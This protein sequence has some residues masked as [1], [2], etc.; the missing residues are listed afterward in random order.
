MVG[1]LIKQQ[2]IG[3]LPDDQ[4]QHQTGFFAAGEALGDFGDF[5]ALEAKTAEIIT[6]LLFHFL[7]SKARHVLNR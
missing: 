6:Q 1:W 3:T 5:I 2:Q 7:R 4:R